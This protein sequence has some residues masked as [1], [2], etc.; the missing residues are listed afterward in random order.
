MCHPSTLWPVSAGSA[1]C[2]D[3]LLADVVRIMHAGKPHAYG[4]ATDACRQ[5][6]KRTQRLLAMRVYVSSFT[7]TRRTRTM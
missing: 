2:V 1:G 3:V 4:A 6:S 7:R 5:A